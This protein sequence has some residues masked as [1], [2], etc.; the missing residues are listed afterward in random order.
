MSQPATQTDDFLSPRMMLLAPYLILALVVFAAYANTFNNGFLFDDSLIIEINEYL[1]GWNHIGD[2]LTTS[3][4]SGAHIDGGFYRPV[5]IL[6]YLIAFQLGD[7]NAFWFHLLNLSLHI[8]N[9]CFVYRLGTKLGFNAKG[10]FLAA[11]VWGVHPLHTEAVTYMSATADTLSAFFCLWA[12]VVLLP[13]ITQK[14]ILKVIPLFLLG[15]VS[16]EV[17]VMFPLL[18]MACL[19]YLNDKRLSPRTYYRTWPLW[20]ITLIFVAWRSTAEG[21]DG[22][23]SYDRFYAM[24]QFSDMKLYA[25]EPIYR[26]YT[27]F[28]T[29]PNYLELLIWPTGLHM[30]RVFP[31]QS[32]VSGV[33]AAGIMMI[34]FAAGHIAYSCRIKRGLELSW[35]FLWFAAAHSPDTGLLFPMNSLFLEHWMY[36][37]SVGLFLGIAQTLVVLTKNK[38]RALPV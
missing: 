12:I 2:I 37:P 38:P 24:P 18:V 9:T 11:L 23:Q 30:E 10:V 15:L 13:D 35:G 6:L 5:Q 3:T 20:L 26:I 14:K 21:F 19:F 27:F 29:L 16:K 36:L 25:A 34:V 1:R 33:V 31:I 17:T 4:T 32:Y 22:P 7:G 28:A 8:A